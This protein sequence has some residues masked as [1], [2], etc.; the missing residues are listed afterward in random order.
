MAEQLALG[1]HRAGFS[2]VAV[3]PHLVWGPGD[4]QL[5]ERIVQ[6]SRSRRLALVA[7]GTALIDTTYV[8]NAVDA[9]VAA[10]DRADSVGGASY[11]VSNGE[12]RP[13]AEI[14]SA[15]CAAA[16]VP[17]PRLSVPFAA[18]WVAG[19]AVEGVWSWRRREDDPPI[20]RFLAEQLATAHWFDQRQTHAALQ[21]APRVS[22]AEGFEHLAAYY[23]R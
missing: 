7:G 10:L 11:V 3:R 22:L 6:R 9:L 1:A 18:A 8:D 15:F 23:R 14:V 2:V 16:R 4:T 12:P 21:W 19:A 20:T 17:G 13:V 5:V